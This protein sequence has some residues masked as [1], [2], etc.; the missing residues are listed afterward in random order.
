MPQ[1][2]LS[3]KPPPDEVGTPHD[4]TAE[5]VLGVMG[6][7]VLDRIVDLPG[8]SAP[9]EGLGG[10]AYALAAARVA[11]PRGWSVL[12]IARVGADAAPRVRDWLDRAGLTDR[13]LIEAEEPNNRV[14]LRYRD[15]TRRVEILR[16]GVAP[17]DWTELEPLVTGCDAL[18]VNFISG[19]ELD[20][21]AA[22]RVRGAVPGL[23]YADLHSLFLGSTESGERVPRLLAD[24]LAWV[25]CFDA[26]QVNADEF[27]LLAQSFGISIHDDADDEVARRAMAHG[28]GLLCRTD[29]PRGATCWS[30]HEDVPIATDSGRAE[31]DRTVVRH[32]IPAERISDGDPTGCGDVWGATM[33]CGLL[34]GDAPER[35][36]AL[37]T[38]FAAVALECSGADA[39]IFGL[40]PEVGASI[41]QSI[42]QREVVS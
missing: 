41:R 32:Q 37:A 19:H 23:V 34:A 25:A 39:L 40:T 7:F 2:S 4:T 6:T 15:D 21:E 20:L 22:G 31:G 29:G 26:V 17:W 10:I 27:A 42:A 33:A 13:G 16:G 12:P 8:R 28:P 9:I 35:A 30:R 3:P 38:G 18:V 5:A 36:A 24:P 14:E 1:G 11:H